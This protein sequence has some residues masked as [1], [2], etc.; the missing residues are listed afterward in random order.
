MVVLRIVR[1]KLALSVLV[2]LRHFRFDLRIHGSCSPAV[3]PIKHALSSWL[4]RSAS[5]SVAMVMRQKY[6]KWAEAKIHISDVSKLRD[7][8]ET[9]KQMWGKQ[10]FRPSNSTP[11]DSGWLSR[12]LW[13][14]WAGGWRRLRWWQSRSMGWLQPVLPG[15]MIVLYNQ[16][17]K[18]NCIHLPCLS[19]L[20]SKLPLAEA[21]VVST[22]QVEEGYHCTRAPSP[23]GQGRLNAEQRIYVMVEG[24]RLKWKRF[25][26]ENLDNQKLFEIASLVQNSVWVWIHRK[27]SLPNDL[28]CIGNVAVHLLNLLFSRCGLDMYQKLW[29]WSAELWWGKAMWTLQRRRVSS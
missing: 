27:Q 9:C 8:W 20:P 10:F 24:R 5:Q 6:N 1:S 11:E 21:S 18:S 28:L 26:L 7:I 13:D 17:S 23:G 19:A 2:G 4:G 22:S 25:V 12:N 3:A 14:D 15:R 16:S 29:R